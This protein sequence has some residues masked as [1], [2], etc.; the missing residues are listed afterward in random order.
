VSRYRDELTAAR[1]RAN[2]LES[3]LEEHEA[4]LE[5]RDEQIATLE[6]ELGEREDA[7]VKEK[8]RLARVK[9]SRR[10]HEAEEIEVD[11]PEPDGQVHRRELVRLDA[12]GGT[13]ATQLVVFV[14]VIIVGFLIAMG[15]ILH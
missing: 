3:A 11:E 2:S 6:R 8:K 14:F 10:K 5:A 15:A 7:L 13:S 1:A 12:R 9:R 4:E